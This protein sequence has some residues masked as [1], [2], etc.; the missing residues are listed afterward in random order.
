MSGMLED[1]LREML[2]ARVETLP[3]ADDIA[4]RVIQRGRAARRRRAV[5]SLL[6]V[7][8][9]LILVVGGVASLGIVWPGGSPRVTNVAGFDADAV[10][11]ESAAPVPTPGVDT[12]VGLDIRS[13]EQLLTAD[14]R[15][16]DLG[17]VGEVTRVYRVP[18]GWIYAG[19]D[20]VRLL[21]TDGTSLA[22]SGEDGRWVLSADGRRFAF[23]LGT[24][25]YVASITS[26]GMAV[27]KDVPVPADSWPVV[28]TADR[29][30]VSVAERGYGVVDLTDP[31]P[32]TL[33][34]DVTAVYGVRGDRLLGLVRS[35]RG[36][37]D[38]L[39]E[40]TGVGGALVP[41]R[42]G[43]CDFQ[44][45]PTTLRVGYTSTTDGLAPDG[46]RLAAWRAGGITVVDIAS[47]LTGSTRAVE[48][49]GQ[50]L[51][52]PVWADSRTLVTGDASTV[53]RC[54]VDGT[55]Q[56]VPLPE[57]IGEDW[58]LVPRL[59]AEASGQ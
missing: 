12:G 49:A 52:A 51:V 56:T 39:A 54:T 32:P 8:A 6:G 7:S 34:A 55:E 17:G 27:V 5:A 26:T 4:T 33:N 58:Q 20:Q 25:L 37:A 29:V 14:G 59:L 18:A 44:R 10:A 47:A 28:L 43:A 30:V 23:Q 40:L 57:G 9:A 15:R 19:V 13:G 45:T 22:L 36:Q 50:A 48:C 1:S 21:R 53:I 46:R 38:C 41:V 35:P 42:R 24:T 31:A 11:P 2:A 16:L 3:V